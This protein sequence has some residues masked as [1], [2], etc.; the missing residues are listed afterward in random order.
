M[1]ADGTLVG[2]IKQ[3]SALVWVSA[4]PK[5]EREVSWEIRF[6]LRTLMKEGEFR[7]VC[8]I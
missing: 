8:R 2:H 7:V 1:R 3:K 6:D 4:T 5:E